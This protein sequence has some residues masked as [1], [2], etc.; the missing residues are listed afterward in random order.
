MTI[1]SI[2]LF[3][4]VAF[5]SEVSLSSFF[6]KVVNVVT[7]TRLGG[8]LLLGEPLGGVCTCAA[9]FTDFGVVGSLEEDD[10]ELVWENSF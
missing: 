8:R 9:R 5:S 3:C 10:E 1:V 6:L 4:G 2:G 7:C